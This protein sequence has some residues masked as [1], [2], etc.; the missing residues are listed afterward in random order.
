MQ[1]QNLFDVAAKQF[2]RLAFEIDELRFDVGNISGRD[3]LPCPG[4]VCRASILVSPRENPI[5]VIDSY[6]RYEVT[7]RAQKRFKLLSGLDTPSGV[8]KRMAKISK[9]FPSFGH[10]AAS[11]FFSTQHICFIV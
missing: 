1:Q 10:Q 7:M 11:D 6:R 5:R 3:S 4:V 9:R 2:A 8:Q